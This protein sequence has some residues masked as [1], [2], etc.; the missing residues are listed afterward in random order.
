MISTASSYSDWTELY[1]K[2]VF[3]ESELEKSSDPGMTEILKLQENEAKI[4]F[5]KF[6][7]NNYLELA[8][9]GMH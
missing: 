7:I 9:S 6:I 3:W 8:Q 1:R 4:L 5:S 2:I